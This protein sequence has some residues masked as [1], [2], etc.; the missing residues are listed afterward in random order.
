M[1]C[2][3]GDICFK[4]GRKMTFSVL[5]PAIR[6]LEGIFL[7]KREEKMFRRAERNKRNQS[8]TSVA[9]GDKDGHR[10][11][12]LAKDYSRSKCWIRSQTQGRKQC[13]FERRR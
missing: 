3:E 13:Y 6:D 7:K 1:R 8:L 2:N 5:G 4:E 9:I 10:R 12:R 11:R